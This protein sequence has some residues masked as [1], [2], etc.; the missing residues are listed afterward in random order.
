MKCQTVETLGMSLRAREHSCAAFVTHMTAADVTI[1]SSFY[2]CFLKEE[3]RM[4]A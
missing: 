3:L 2:F 1:R 4:Q